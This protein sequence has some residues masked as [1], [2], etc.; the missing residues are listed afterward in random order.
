VR[1]PYGKTMNVRYVLLTVKYGGGNIK[2]LGCFSRDGVV[3]LHQVEGVHCT[4]VHVQRHHATC[5][6]TFRK[7]KHALWVA[8]Q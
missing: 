1:R 4:V 8:R 6:D 5:H 7:A 2:V 3:S